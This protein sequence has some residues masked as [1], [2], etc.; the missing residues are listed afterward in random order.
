[1]DDYL[2]RDMRSDLNN[3]NL[4]GKEEDLGIKVGGFRKNID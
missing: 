3:H 2:E 4:F 1:M